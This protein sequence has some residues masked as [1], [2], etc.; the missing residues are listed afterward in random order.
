M[1]ELRNAFPVLVLV[2]AATATLA[3]TNRSGQE[4]PAVHPPVAKKIAKTSQIHGEARVDEY[5]WLREKS[6]PEVISYLE[7]ENAYTEAVMKPSQALQKKLYDE[8][9]GRIQETDLS[10]PYRLGSFWYYARTE[11]GK[12]YP[13]RCRRKGDRERQS[14]D[15]PEEILLDLNALAVGH[16]FLGLGGFDVSDDENLLAYSTD[17]TGFRQYT[18]QFK[19][20]RTG[21][22]LPDKI[23]KV[24]DS[25]WA[26]DN[27][28]T[29]YIVEDE[30]KRPARLYRH[31]L[32][33]SADEL[34]YEEKDELYRIG[35]S[36]SRSKDYLFLTSASS[37]TSEVRI[38]RASQPAG[39][40]RLV[41][42]RKDDLEYY[43][44]HQGDRFFI[45]TNDN[46]KNFRVMTAPVD[47]PEKDHWTEFVPTRPGVTIEDIDLF[48]NHAVLHEK[49]GGLDKIRVIELATGA[50]HRI[51]FPEPAYSAFGDTNPEFDSDRFRFRYQSFVTPQ[52]VFDYDMTSHQRVLLK[53]TPVLGGY[54]RSRYTTDRIWAKAADGT[55]IPIS[56]VYRKGTKRNGKAP[57]LLNGYG[58]YGFALPITFSVSR[59]S[60][61]DRGVTF[62]V[63][64]IRGGGEIG[65]EWH[66]AGK[67]M[68]KKNTFTDFIDCAEHLIREKYTSKSRLVA[69]GGSAGG[70]LM[71]AITNLRPDLFHAISSHVPF[72]DVMNTMLD[73]S[74][75]LTVGEYLEWGNPNEKPAYDYM[76]SY[77]PYTNIA[78]KKYPAILIQTSLNDSQ[79]MYW[80]PAKYVA[81]L[82]AHKTD[83][84]VLL[85]KTNMGAGHGGASGRYDALKE[86]A[87]ELAFVLR[88]QGIRE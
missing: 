50:D 24:T 58:A 2:F 23:E 8:M 42:P 52:S 55:K 81:K 53:E 88:Q 75:P 32:G 26:G 22:T 62:A 83:D 78:R 37:E 16:P 76:K 87:F 80:E 6:N 7:A 63:A 65:E 47:H 28:T 39:E 82:R 17:T 59:V 18:L 61:L 5:F 48:R 49:E 79:V 41:S 71:G 54:D 56:L 69:Q 34:I 84:N 72:V 60:L 4:G 31:V 27:R 15:A 29:F 46:A 44:D 12:Q 33:Q 1:I 86:T 73:P 38:L 10:V 43:L 85:L 68:A 51:E 35:I 13:I 70:L 19:N 14:P 20:L 57:L 77:C 36:R 45:R 3:K 64:H 40:F 25:A 21:E 30:A 11:Q 67:L 9:V 66:D 74:L